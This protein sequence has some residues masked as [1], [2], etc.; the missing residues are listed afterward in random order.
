M[1]VRENSEPDS[2]NTPAAE[3]WLWLAQRISA[4]VLAVVI[5]IHLGTIIY[6]VRGGLTAAEIIARIGGSMGWT[7]FYGVFVTAVAVH[8]P[9]GLRAILAEMTALPRRRVDL[10]CF[11]AAVLIG[12]FGYRVVHGFHQ[13]G[14]IS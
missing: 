7:V 6:A 10:L 11:I 3:T 13:L 4:V 8:A 1:N 2:A 12:Y 9:I 5:V 14:A